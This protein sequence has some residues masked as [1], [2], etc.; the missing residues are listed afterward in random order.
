MKTPTKITKISEEK[1]F[2]ER[3][4]DNGNIKF[5]GYYI[6]MPKE[7]IDEPIG[8]KIKF[9][10]YETGGI[11]SISPKDNF[12]IKKDGYRVGISRWYD[13]NGK[14]EQKRMYENGMVNGLGEFYYATG[15]I[16]IKAMYKENVPNGLQEIFWENGKIKERGNRG[17]GNG[18]RVGVWEIFD[19]EGKHIKDVMYEA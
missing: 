4:W 8:T 13:E 6:E 10:E 15:Q 19:E 17:D 5:S 3:F 16:K 12:Q 14:I 2:I 18:K 7:L 9:D 11:P 1:I